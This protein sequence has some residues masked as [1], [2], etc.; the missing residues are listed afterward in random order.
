MIS[1]LERKIK[2]KKTKTRQSD[3]YKITEKLM[4]VT[5]VMNCMHE[6]KEYEK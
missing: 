4:H 6:D 5:C 3:H 1:I 2:I